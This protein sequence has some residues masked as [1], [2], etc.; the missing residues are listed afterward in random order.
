VA[1]GGRAAAG[2]RGALSRDRVIDAAIAMA[3]A[4]GM[5]AVSMRRLAQDLGV[6]AMTLYHY[7]SNKDDILLGMVDRV[8]EEM[9]HPRVGLDWKAELRAAAVSSHEVLV[10]HPWAASLL[11]AGPGVSMARLRWMDAVLG[12]LRGAGFTA[13]HTDHAYHAL[14]SHIMGFSLWLVGISAGLGRLGSLDEFLARLDVESLPH[15]GEHVEQHLAKRDADE[16]EFEFGLDLILDGLERQLAGAGSR[17][18]RRS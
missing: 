10:R 15:L 5:D 7:V 1:R 18:P 16:R 11:L 6:E 4:Q 8:V 9:R 2:T 12:C 13:D 17:G 3:D 14:D